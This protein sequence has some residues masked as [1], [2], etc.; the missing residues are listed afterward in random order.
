MK[1]FLRN[2]F[3]GGILFLVPLVFL[4]MIVSKANDI[5]L[6]ISEPLGKKLNE[7]F[8]GLDGSRILAVVLLVVFCFLCG[9]LFRLAIAQK[10]MKLLEDYV[11]SHLPG[12]TLFKSFAT[13]VAGGD[14]AGQMTAVLVQEENS[15]KPGLLVETH[16]EWST[17]YFPEVPK[18]DSG[19]VKMV[20]TDT[21]HK[22]AATGLQ[23][24]KTMKGFGK[25]M[26]SWKE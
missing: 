25:G 6:K 17:V 20:P 9:L 7:G 23:F 18:L 12:Y 8:L 14:T 1:T 16:G 26:G 2:T 22:V 24:M 15:W 5:M 11:L 13:D 3:T 4:W 19:E 21:I 10:T